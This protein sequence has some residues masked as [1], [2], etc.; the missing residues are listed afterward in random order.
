L[1]TAPRFH[2]SPGRPQPLEWPRSVSYPLPPSGRACKLP[3]W[4][5]FSQSALQ[6]AVGSDSQSSGAERPPAALLAS[7]VCS[8]TA[9]WGDQGTSL[10]LQL[11]AYPSRF[12][13]RA[14]MARPGSSG[15]SDPMQSRPL[16]GLPS[17]VSHGGTTLGRLTIRLGSSERR[18]DKLVCE[19]PAWCLTSMTLRQQG[20]RAMPSGDPRCAEATAIHHSRLIHRGLR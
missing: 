6:H 12:H 17:W 2:G 16:N 7:P 20:A 5:A 11:N 9:R 14:S 1:C 13:G 15:D 8:S 18:L 3:I 4:Q 10:T 19:S